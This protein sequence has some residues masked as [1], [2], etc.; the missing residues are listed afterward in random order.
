MTYLLSALAARRAARLVTL[1]QGIPD[2]FRI[3]S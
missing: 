2:S 1:D 3:P